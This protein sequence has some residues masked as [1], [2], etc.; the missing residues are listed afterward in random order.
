[1]DS[2]MNHQDQCNNFP[3]LRLSK[4]SMI[5]PYILFSHVLMIPFPVGSTKIR[6]R[7]S[8]LTQTQTNVVNGKGFPLRHPLPLGHYPPLDHKLHPITAFK[9]CRQPHNLSGSAENKYATCYV[10]SQAQPTAETPT[11]T[12]LLPDILQL[13]DILFY[14]V[15][16]TNTFGAQYQAFPFT[17]LALKQS[18]HNRSPPP[19]LPTP[20]PQCKINLTYRPITT[21]PAFIRKTVNHFD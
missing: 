9:N 5:H 4:A 18:L 16:K 12:R 15:I 7:N 19:N 17:S 1:M 11:P 3:A 8:Q 10:I 14:W 21:K 2:L 13:N 20:S 6:F